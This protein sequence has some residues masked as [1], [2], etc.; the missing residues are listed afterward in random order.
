MSVLA[1]CAVVGI[2]S[3]E[4]SGPHRVGALGGHWYLVAYD[5]RRHNWRLG[6]IRT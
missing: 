5:L 2:D 6:P 1:S 4:A 3:K